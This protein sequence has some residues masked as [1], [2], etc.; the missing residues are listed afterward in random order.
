[1][2]ETE[3]GKGW[4]EQRNW[5][6]ELLHSFS[7]AINSSLELP[8]VL[9]TLEQLLIQ[10]LDVPGG[11]ILFYQPASE[12]FSLERSWGL[13][14]QVV[15]ELGT[16]LASG[17]RL[18]TMIQKDKV[19]FEENFRTIGLFSEWK[20]DTVRPDWQ[21]FLSLPLPAKEGEVQGVLFLFSRVPQPFDQTQFVFFETLRR[22]VGV[23]I[24]NARLFEQVSTG[25]K[26]L[27]RLAQRVFSAQEEERYRVSRELHDEA[28]QAL[29]GLKIMLEMLMSDLGK[30]TGGVGATEAKSIYEQLEGAVALCEETMGRIRMLAHDLR[31]AALENLGLNLTLQGF[32][33]D[34]ANRTK[35]PIKYTG[36]DLPPLPDAVEICLYRFLQ[37][38]LTNVV[39]HAQANEVKV[40]LHCDA[41]TISLS[42]ADDGQGF[43]LRSAMHVS[44]ENAGIGLSGMQERIESVGGKLLVNSRPGEGTR[45]IAWIPY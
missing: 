6:L 29:T 43:D 18:R 13:P 14:T 27:R 12:H 20:L 31:P 30:A 39:K 11:A 17:S 37:E 33:R 25:Q 42:V 26:R 35:L 7:S 34:F 45:L 24:Q 38:A 19:I 2:Q 1:M 22:E 28:G 44:N 21:S 40:D 15:Q 3:R 41:N 23:A 5:E 32:C 10:H 16:Y 4:M 9:K 36:E 8:Q